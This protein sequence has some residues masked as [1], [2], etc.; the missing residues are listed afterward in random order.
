MRAAVSPVDLTSSSSDVSSES[1]ETSDDDSVKYDTIKL[2]GRRRTVVPSNVSSVPAVVEGTLGPDQLLVVIHNNSSH[3]AL[4]TSSPSA[5]LSPAS[6][7][8]AITA[9]ATTTTQRRRSPS[10]SPPSYK[11]P[12]LSPSPSSV[13]S[14]PRT[15]KGFIEIL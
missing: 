13:S 11:K 8:S 2:V 6:S 1:D 15:G 7:L 14:S 3:S 9:E 12:P 10:P 5:R 4:P